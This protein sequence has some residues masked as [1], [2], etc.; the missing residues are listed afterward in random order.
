MK[1]DNWIELFT[2]TL[3]NMNYLN[4][5]FMY[6]NVPYWTFPPSTLYLTNSEGDVIDGQFRLF[7]E[8]F[9][10]FG[11]IHYWSIFVLGDRC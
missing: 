3:N 4:S 7:R 8:S 9:M 5:S 6:T 11:I 2:S 10:V 1:S